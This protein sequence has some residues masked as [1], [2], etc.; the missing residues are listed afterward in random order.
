VVAVEPHAPTAL[1]RAL[2]RRLLRSA[3]SRVSVSSMAQDLKWPSA[4][5]DA[6]VQIA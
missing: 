3:A 2:V 5:L 6:I 1:L 4:A